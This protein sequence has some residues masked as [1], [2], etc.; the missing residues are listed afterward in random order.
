MVF[1]IPREIEQNQSAAKNQ[2]SRC[3]QFIPCGKYWYLK[4][5]IQLYCR[6][7][8]KVLSKYHHHHHHHHLALCVN[9][10]Q[11]LS[12]T[13][14][15]D[16]CRIE[17]RRHPA[18]WN[19]G[20][21][22]LWSSRHLKRV[23]TIEYG[24]SRVQTGATDDSLICIYLWWTRVTLKFILD[25]S[26]CKHLEPPVSYFLRVGKTD[27]I[28]GLSLRIT[29]I[30]SIGCQQSLEFLLGWLQLPKHFS[31]GP[32][33]HA[34]DWPWHTVQACAIF[35]CPTTKSQGQMEAAVRYFASMKYVGQP[36]WACFACG[37]DRRTK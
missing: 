9:M 26:N 12:V 6:G 31:S 28:V 17:P 1:S 25:V 13:G 15:L 10:R 22:A 8:C 16:P 23:S 20:G 33:R 11:P 32:T 30:H 21:F 34:R 36:R 29:A 5:R 14:R 2:Q 3:I 24:Y 19:R 35:S 27:S 7:I 37:S 18:S 4:S